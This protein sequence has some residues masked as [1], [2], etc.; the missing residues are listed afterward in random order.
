MKTRL[1]SLVRQPS[2]GPLRNGPLPSVSKLSSVIVLGLLVGMVGCSTQDDLSGCPVC[3]APPADQS[4]DAEADD[5]STV[6]VTTATAPETTD[7]S[8]PPI[9]PEPTDATAPPQADS[10]EAGADVEAGPIE[11][12]TFGA[13]C[14]SN[15]D[16]FSGWCVEG[17]GGFIC[18]QS[19]DEACPEG[20]DC[21]AVGGQADVAFL[22]MPRLQKL[23]AP[24]T[25]DEQC[26]GGACLDLDGS[27]QCGYACQE[28]DDCPNGYL[29]GPHTEEG[30]QGSWCQP[31]TGSC[32]CS[33]DLNGG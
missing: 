6:D 24:C 10:D 3:D 13:P 31:V 1:I 17:T 28:D 5:A 2:H 19:C 23:C 11:A 22:C 21:K 29:C 27:S 15:S 12:G 9:E 4:A 33:V 8:D 18:T 26:N 30:A 16:C 20:Y 25:T 32:T 7:W 14:I